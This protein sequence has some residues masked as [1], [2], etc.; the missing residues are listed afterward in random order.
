MVDRSLELL[1]RKDS[2]LSENICLIPRPEIIRFILTGKYRIDA[3]CFYIH[4]ADTIL[5]EN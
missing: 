4:K 3:C 5:L 1:V 2:D